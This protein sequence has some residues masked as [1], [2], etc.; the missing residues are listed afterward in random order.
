MAIQVGSPAPNFEAK[1]YLRSSGAIKDLR[2][3]DFR[4]KWLCLYF[5]PVSFSPVCLTEL[6]AFESARQEFEHRDCQLLACST[7]SHFVHMA[8][9]E[10]EKGLNDLGYPI[11]SDLTQQISMDYG[12]LI[13]EKG[14]AL[15][16]T[17]LIDP[18]QI[19]R[20]HCVNDLPVGRNVNAILRELDA[21]QTREMC[22][23]NWKPG[24]S[25]LGA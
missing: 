13:P 16:A 6:I 21:L 17:F 14:V 7:D 18:D 22:P 3:E 15:R 20:W 11:L 24:D 19:V 25:P 1:S 12:V 10:S 4:G 2:L 8:W 5:F 9:C 23:C